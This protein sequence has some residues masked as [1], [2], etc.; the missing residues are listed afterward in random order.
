MTYTENRAWNVQIWVG[1][2]ENYQ[3]DCTTIKRELLC[4]THTITEVERICQNFVDK[5]KD[6]VTVTPTK[7]IYTGGIEEGV[8]VGF[9]QYPRFPMHSK[10]ITDRAV[11]LAEELMKE[12][13]QCRVTVTTPEWS[14]MIS[15]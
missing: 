10:E 11:K 7:F 6:C 3:D 9:I 13:N 15:K 1:L 4:K 5:E 8:V 14:I 12:L 2:K